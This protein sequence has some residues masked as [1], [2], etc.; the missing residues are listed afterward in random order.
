MVSSNTCKVNITCAVGTIYNSQ[1]GACQKPVCPSS[2]PIF[3]T[4]TGVCVAC[5]TGTVYDPLT[6]TCKLPVAVAQAAS[7]ACPPSSPYWNPARLACEVC[8]LGQRMSPS[9]HICV[10]GVSHLLA[11]PRHYLQNNF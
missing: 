9:L 10:P 8:P 11:I 1:T 7:S 4:V 5:P 6:K 2:N 3:D